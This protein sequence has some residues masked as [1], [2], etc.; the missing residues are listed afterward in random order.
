MYVKSI[1]VL[2][3]PIIEK[4]DKR[5]YG[6]ES[7]EI[8]GSSVVEDATSRNYKYTYYEDNRR[9]GFTRVRRGG[10]LYILR[11]TKASRVSETR[12]IH[13]IY[14][15][16]KTKVYRSIGNASFFLCV[17]APSHRVFIEK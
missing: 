6:R 14:E 2:A 5:T 15:K 17:L 13:V 3:V 10:K 9:K 16:Q 11:T 12:Y 1:Y 4:M 7:M 8:F